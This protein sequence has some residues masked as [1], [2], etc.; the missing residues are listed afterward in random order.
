MQHK[1]HIREPLKL[2]YIKEMILN[3]TKAVNGKS[4]FRNCFL[5]TSALIQGYTSLSDEF[6]IFEPYQTWHEIKLSGQ[7]FIS[8]IH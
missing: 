8:C 2:M 4:G 7:V 6:S 1:T 3:L 5:V